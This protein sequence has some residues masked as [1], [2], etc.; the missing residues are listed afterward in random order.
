MPPEKEDLAYLWDMADAAQAIRKF[1]ED[2]T[3]HHYVQNS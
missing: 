2:K 1:L 3:F